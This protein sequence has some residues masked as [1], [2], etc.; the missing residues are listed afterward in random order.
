MKAIYTYFIAVVLVISIAV[1][2][3]YP[4]RFLNVHTGDKITEDIV[5]STPAGTKITEDIVSSMPAGTK[6][7]EDIQQKTPKVHVQHP[8]TDPVPGYIGTRYAPISP[9]HPSPVQHRW[10]SFSR[11][12]QAWRTAYFDSRIPVVGGPT[13]VTIVIHNYSHGSIPKIY[14][15]YV[16]SNGTEMSQKTPAELLKYEFYKR[17]PDRINL[18]HLARCKL[19]TN[20][21]PHYVFLSSNLSFS[22]SSAYIPLYYNKPEKKIKFAV[23]LQQAL[24]NEVD[25]ERIAAG[26]ELI[27]FYYQHSP[28]NIV[29]LVQKY[30]DEGLVEALDWN[31]NISHSEIH[32]NAEF[33]VINDC[34]Y[35]TF[36]RAEYVAF[37]DIDEFLVPREH[38]TWH[39]LMKEIDK[40]EEMFSQFRFCQSHWHDVGEI[41]PG[42]LPSFNK[43]CVNFT[44]PPVMFKR[45]QRTQNIKCERLH[46]KSLLKPMGIKRSGVHTI[47]LIESFKRYEVPETVGLMHHYRTDD[48][49]P[50]EKK[51]TDF[52]L[53]KYVE[54]IMDGLKQKLC[55]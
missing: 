40:P 24:Y 55:S 46:V 37:T 33:A 13:V 11:Y 4:Q 6:I 2:T 23:C 26:A 51:V 41:L 53:S 34:L 21:I 17:L 35:R 15:K 31:I 8:W 19:P 36:H 1:L 12:T 27:T 3:L 14:C 47:D 39:E 38:R 32:A 30:V 43:S 22:T 45:T 52:V 18:V 5:S 44:K 9:K 20:E 16:Y 7:T 42:S 54:D 48:I 28:S 29:E 10:T 50:D 25:H 49:T